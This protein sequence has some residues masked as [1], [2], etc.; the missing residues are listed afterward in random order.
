[1]DLKV[2]WEGRLHFRCS[3]HKK[4][5]R[6]EREIPIIKG[7]KAT[8]GG[9]SYIYYLVCGDGNRSVCVYVCTNSPN[10]IH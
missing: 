7:Y 10:R 3:Y 6:K 9:D 2:F 5:K 8:F 4:K 1:M